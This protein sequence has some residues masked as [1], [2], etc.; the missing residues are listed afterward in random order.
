[1]IAKTYSCSLVGIDAM[2]VEVEVDLSP[3]LPVFY[4]S[5]TAG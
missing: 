3:G 5:G 1:M 2:L 4:H